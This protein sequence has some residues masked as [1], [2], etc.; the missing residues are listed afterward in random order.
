MTERTWNCPFCKT[1]I[2]TDAEECPECKRSLDWNATEKQAAAV[3]RVVIAGVDMSVG[4][5]AALMFKLCV[6]FIPVALVVGVTA[7]LVVAL[8]G[9]R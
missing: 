5:L 9:R 3:P 6:A 4:D 8:L 2:P 1:E 7:F